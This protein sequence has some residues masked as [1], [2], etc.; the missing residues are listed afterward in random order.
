MNKTRRLTV[1]FACWM[2]SF[3]LLGAGCRQSSPT[4]GA[5]GDGFESSSWENEDVLAKPDFQSFFGKWEAASVGT[6]IEYK[7]IEIS[8]DR[9]IHIEKEIKVDGTYCDFSF[10]GTHG[11]LQKMKPQAGI[12]DANLYSLS[13]FMETGTS[14]YVLSPESAANPGCSHAQSLA[15]GQHPSWLLGEA[16]RF[17]VKLQ[18]EHAFTLGSGDLMVQRETAPPVVVFPGTATS[19]ST[20]Q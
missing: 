20:E 6:G 8:T 3:S 18:S 15:D 4:S 16:K 19:I 13:F 11:R 10:N 5:D 1:S 14:A 7:V 12:D 2:A 9:S 17:S